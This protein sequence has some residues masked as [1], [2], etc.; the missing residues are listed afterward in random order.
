MAWTT[1]VSQKTWR[2]YQRGGCWLEPRQYAA[3]QAKARAHYTAGQAWQSYGSGDSHVRSGGKRWSQRKPWHSAHSPKPR[4]NQSPMPQSKLPPTTSKPEGP[5]MAV[6]LAQLEQQRLMLDTMRASMESKGLEPPPQPKIL[7]LSQDQVQAEDRRWTQRAS[8]AHSEILKWEKE[9]QEARENLRN[10]RRR[11]ERA[12]HHLDHHRA[13]LH[14]TKQPMR[15]EEAW[16][17]IV[18]AFEPT[19]MSY[20][21]EYEA[22]DACSTGAMSTVEGGGTDWCAKRSVN[23]P[24][25]T[26]TQARALAL[27]MTQ[28]Q[29]LHYA[30]LL[31]MIQG[32]G[33]WSTELQQELEVIATQ[34]QA[35]MLASDVHAD[36]QQLAMATQATEVAEGVSPDNF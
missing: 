19:D 25:A 33:Q 30:A 32:K 36:E 21:S 16:Q 7:Q 20:D 5:A 22:D 9:K 24:S 18:T 6:L 12:Q 11:A 4:P 34:I 8:A 17:E 15:S 27:P 31:R 13:K 26:A 28:A 3:C 35:E 2:L 10:A 1:H 23:A 29:A 14:A